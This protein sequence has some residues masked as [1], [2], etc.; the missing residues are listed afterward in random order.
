MGKKLVKVS[1]MTDAL[2]NTGY[3]RKC[4]KKGA[5]DTET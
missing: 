5:E 4:E 3:K 2:R 1:A